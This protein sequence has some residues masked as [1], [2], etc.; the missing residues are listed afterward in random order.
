MARIKIGDSVKVITGPHRG[1]VG[2]VAKLHG[3]KARVEV[4]GLP[5]L[6]R[7]LKSGRHPKHSEGGIVEK[8]RSVHVSNVMLMSQELQRPVR[9]GVERDE[10]GKKTRVARGRNVQSKVV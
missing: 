6:K 3:K 10:S 1:H 9:T 8:P 7:H 4:E 5:A 2:K